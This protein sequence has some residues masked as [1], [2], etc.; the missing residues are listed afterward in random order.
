MSTLAR[1]AVVLVLCSAC[2]ASRTSHP[3]G[4]PAPEP[5]ST[6]VAAP[7]AS[8]STADAAL[9]AAVSPER[10]GAL[11]CRLYDTPE[12]AFLSVLEEHPL[13]L[14]VGE[15][16]AQK[17]S[18]AVASATRRFSESFL[19]ELRDKASDLV[20]ELWLP[21][22]RCLKQAKRV[23]ARQKPVTE[24]QADTNQNEYVVFGKR[25]EALGIRPHA[26]RPTCEQYEQIVTA[27]A[28]DL[29][30]MLS[31]IAS[32]TA[33][34]TKA[35][36]ARN[37]ELQSS[38]LVV[39]YGGALHNDLEPRKGRE[40]W[41]FGPELQALT[42]GRYVELDLIVPEYIKDNDSWRSLP[43]Y[44]HFDPAKQPSKTTLFR[45]GPGSYAL[46]F[47]RSVGKVPTPTASAP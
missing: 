42:Q 41:S 11:E 20:L 36:L 15:A 22:P 25:S 26:L 40:A 35:L 45:L 9:A 1:L 2:S 14:A 21:D 27:G 43:W 28:G 18:E 47:P 39:L 6:S 32:Q 29:N 37:R 23:E 5:L 30:V 8:T 24:T 16:H 12:Q 34:Q 38:K 13:V 33:A 3:P 31:L 7:V 19:P 17:G 46:I 10:C 4:R 44:P